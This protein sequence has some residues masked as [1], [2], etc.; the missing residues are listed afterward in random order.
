MQSSVLLL[1]LSFCVAVVVLVVCQCCQRT[2]IHYAVTSYYYQYQHAFREPTCTDSR[3]TPSISGFLPSYKVL[4]RRVPSRGLVI[5]CTP[6][7]VFIASGSS[8]TNRSC[9]FPKFMMACPMVPV[10]SRNACLLTISGKL[11]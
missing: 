5:G 6:C 8:D 7:V 1:S 4:H 11:D 9:T 2:M 10:L 3:L